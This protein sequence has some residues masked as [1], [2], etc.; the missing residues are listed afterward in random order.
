MHTI[1]AQGFSLFLMPF[2]ITI[3]AVPKPCHILDLRL[4]FAYCWLSYA[5]DG[6]MYDVLL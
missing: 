6:L 1:A 5:G 3:L 2:V 4:V